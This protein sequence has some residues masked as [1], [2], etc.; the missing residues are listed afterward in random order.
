[1]YYVKVC[2]LEVRQLVQVE[3]KIKL[4]MVEFYFTQITQSSHF[5]FKNNKQKNLEISFFQKHRDDSHAA[6]PQDDRSLNRR[7]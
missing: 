1:M 6:Q 4:K 7:Y 5:K 3:I 2:G